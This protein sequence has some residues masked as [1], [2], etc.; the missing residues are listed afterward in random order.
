MLIDNL[1]NM[2]MEKF[3]SENY[4]NMHYNLSDS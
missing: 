2:Q 3:E 1:K 4:Q